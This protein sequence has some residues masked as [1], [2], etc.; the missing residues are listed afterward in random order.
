MENEGPP[1]K[2][3]ARVSLRHLYSG[4]RK[5]LTKRHLDKGFEKMRTRQERDEK[6]KNALK[7]MRAPLSRPHIDIHE[8]IIL[9]EN[10]VIKPDNQSINGSTMISLE[11]YS[12]FRN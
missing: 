6:F 7:T 10:S 11:P 2:N 1:G 12:S 4:R 3:F 9:S 5:S 8:S